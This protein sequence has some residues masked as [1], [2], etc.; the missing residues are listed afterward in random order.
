M[1]AVL[2]IAERPAVRERPI[3][4]SAPMVRAILAG[5]KSQTRR[6]VKAEHLAEA[7]DWVFDPNRGEWESGEWSSGQG[8]GAHVEYVR[9]P[10]GVPG[11][12]LWVRETFG[13]SVDWPDALTLPEYEGGHDPDRLLYRADEPRNLTK[14]YGIPWDRVT[15][16]PSIFMPRWASRITLEVTDVRVERL[17]GITE[18]D[19]EREGISRT[20][21]YFDGAAHGVKGTP[22]A[23]ASARDAFVDLWES[24]NAP[25]VTWASNPW[26]WVV[27]FKRV[28]S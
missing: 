15:W 23:F 11:D 20:G 21:Q 19:A 2:A 17:N 22:R 10:Y 1:S 4:F 16:R 24:I 28:A 27:S 14:H 3:L 18:E 5:K 25:R 7:E 26:V 6:I 13:A 9:C 8:V 12:R